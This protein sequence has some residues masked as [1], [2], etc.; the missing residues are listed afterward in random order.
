M[1]DNTFNLDELNELKQ[2]YQL[3]DEKLDGKEIVTPEQ[4]RKASLKNI[5]IFK[6]MYKFSTTWSLFAITPLLVLIFAFSPNMTTIG[7]WI[8]GTYLVIDFLLHFLLMRRMKRVDHSELDLRTLL[9]EES[10]YNKSAFALTCVGFALVFFILTI[11]TKTKFFTRKIN[12]REI[13]IPEPKEPGKFRKAMSWLF[14]GLMAILTLIFAGGIIYNAIGG[15]M[16]LMEFLSRAGFIIITAAFVVNFMFL[17]KYRKGQAGKVSMAI[18]IAVVAGLLM[19]AIP[20]VHT[21]IVSHTFDN[22]ALSPI[23]MGFL[24]LFLNGI[25]R[26]M[27]DIRNIRNK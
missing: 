15:T 2:A 6:R 12:F 4:I 24:T 1:T 16:S 22:G 7:F 3:I 21:A 13:T 23:L 8:L 18:T 14:I 25:I 9:N 10:F 26:N 11:G 20:V 27:K 19:S 5:S 17:D